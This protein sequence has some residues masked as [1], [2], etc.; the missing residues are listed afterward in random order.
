MRVLGRFLLAVGVGMSVLGFG[1]LGAMILGGFAAL[2]RNP[3]QANGFLILEFIAIGVLI[4][5]PIAVFAA[6]WVL[7]RSRANS[8]PEISEGGGRVFF[9]VD[10]L[11]I[12]KCIY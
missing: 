8:R 9:W 1:V 2:E 6:C 3:S 12:T 11:C 10:E 4:C 5:V 7:F